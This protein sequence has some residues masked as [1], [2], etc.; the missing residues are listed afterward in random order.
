MESHCEHHQTCSVLLTD[1]SSFSNAESCL[2]S[3]VEMTQGKMTCDTQTSSSWIPQLQKLHIILQSRN[4]NTECF[5]FILWFFIP[6][7][8]WCPFT[9]DRK[10]CTLQISHCTGLKTIFPCIS[11]NIQGI[12][13]MI[14]IKGIHP[15]EIC[16]YIMYQCFTKPGSSADTVTRLCAGCP[17]NRCLIPARRFFIGGRGDCC[18]QT[19]PG[20][21][22]PLHLTSNY[23]LKV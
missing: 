4:N 23:V 6:H 18:S 8:L 9:A 12:W 22:P 14:P 1:G 2:G 17:D 20:F 5:K 16:I 19:S 7:C 3:A 10:C 21:H 11:L 15:N 13:K